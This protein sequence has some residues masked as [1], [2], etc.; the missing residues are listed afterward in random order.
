MLTSVSC[1]ASIVLEIRKGADN[2]NITSE[3]IKQ[4]RESMGYSQVEFAKNLNLSK[5]TVSNYETG[6]RQPGLDIVISIAQTF[7]ISTDYILGRSNFKNYE[8]QKLHEM[9]FDKHQA[10]EISL[11]KADQFTQ[12]VSSKIIDECYQLV[13]RL[14]YCNDSKIFESYDYILEKLSYMLFFAS[15]ASETIKYRGRV[16]EDPSKYNEIEKKQ[17]AEMMHEYFKEIK[18]Y[19]IDFQKDK[20]L[21][22][23]QLQEVYTIT[24]NKLNEQL[25]NEFKRLYEEE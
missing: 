22:N 8:D 18:E 5:Q 24:L 15:S 19:S 4:I 20:N 12:S 7:N 6:T 14:I 13:E 1:C 17:N 25:E 3:R 11:K 10:L 16:I 23:N 2:L 9:K 21:I